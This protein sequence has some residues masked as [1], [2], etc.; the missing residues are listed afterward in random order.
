MSFNDDLLRLALLDAAAEEFSD[1]LDSE[2]PEVQFSDKYLLRRKRFLKNP[3]AKA[4]SSA[5]RFTNILAKA[6]IFAVVLFG[7]ITSTQ[8][9]MVASANGAI[10]TGK[11]YKDNL[12]YSH[13]ADYTPTVD[14]GYW[15]AA[16]LPEG[17]TEYKCDYAGDF[18][19]VHYLKGSQLIDFVYFHTSAYMNIRMNIG[20]YLIEPVEVNGQA[21]IFHKAE[22]EGMSNVLMW[23]SEDGDLVFMLDAALPADELVKIAQSVEMK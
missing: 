2:S 14:A 4:S 1:I 11:A 6:A 5:S 16:Y 20:H 15:S 21:A 13:T 9:S 19:S 18:C 22:K 7:L 23:F 12:S 17:Y 3:A 10:S 8:L